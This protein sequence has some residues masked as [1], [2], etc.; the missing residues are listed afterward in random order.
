LLSS[1]P[2]GAGNDV[3]ARLG[4]AGSYERRLNFA[5][6]FNAVGPVLATII[7]R[8]FILTGAEYTPPSWL[9]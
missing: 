8:A 1:R 4:T 6:S 3:P 7:G 2:V 9:P 5:H